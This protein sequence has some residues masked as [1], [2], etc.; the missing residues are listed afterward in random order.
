MDIFDMWKVRIEC[1]KDRN[2]NNKKTTI[3]ILRRYKQRHN[4]SSFDNLNSFNP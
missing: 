3:V 1:Y 2:K 4:R